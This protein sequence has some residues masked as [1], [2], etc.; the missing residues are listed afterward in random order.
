MEFL[1]KVGD[2]VNVVLGGAERFITGMFGSSNERR[3]K[4]IG[5]SRDRQGKSQ[6]LPGSILDRINQLE[7]QLE[8]LSDAELRETAAKLRRRLKDGQTLD[9]LVPDAFAA[10]RKSTRLNSS[11][12]RL[13]R[14]P[15]SA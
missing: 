7:P 1:D 4:A 10:D 8:L 3:V 9:D 2:A 5:F 15:S 13:S 11:H 6:I 14:M 12:P